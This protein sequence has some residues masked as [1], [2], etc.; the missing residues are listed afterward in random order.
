MSKKKAK[1]KDSASLNADT[2]RLN[3]VVLESEQKMIVEHQKV[4]Q[5]P[6]RLF[7]QSEVLRAG[8][9]ALAILNSKQRKKVI[10]SVPQL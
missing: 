4:Y 2:N 8:L 9:Y 7:N 3:L 6:R 5:R 1:P 10:D